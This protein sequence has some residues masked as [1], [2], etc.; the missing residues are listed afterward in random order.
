MVEEAKWA[1]LA[2]N[3]YINYDVEYDYYYLIDYE[4]I[5]SFDDLRP[6][7]LKCYSEKVVNSVFES[8]SMIEHDGRLYSGVY[9]IGGF[10]PQAHKVTALKNDGVYT[11]TFYYFEFDYESEDNPEYSNAYNVIYEN[12]RWVFDDKPGVYMLSANCEFIA[13]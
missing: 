9:G 13:E 7:L 1:S 12:G 4:G 5:N 8:G 10:V 2:G 3:A 6:E 11:V